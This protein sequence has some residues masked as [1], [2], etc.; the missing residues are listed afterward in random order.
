MW[1]LDPQPMIAARC[2]SVMI[3]GYK[4]TM[5]IQSGEWGG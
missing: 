1:G 2:M 3:L 5:G 4:F